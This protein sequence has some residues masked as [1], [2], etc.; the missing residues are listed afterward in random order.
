MSAQADTKGPDI[1]NFVSATP[2]H[3]ANL[4]QNLV[5]LRHVAE[6]SATFAAKLTLRALS[7]AGGAESI[8]LSSGSAE[9]MMLSASAESIIPP[10]G[11]A[12]SM[13]LL[14]TESM[15]LSE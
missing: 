3:L 12:E 2:A 13:M 8:I 14:P 6:M 9:S 1:F 15:M 10:A 5:S 7:H 11:A 4:E